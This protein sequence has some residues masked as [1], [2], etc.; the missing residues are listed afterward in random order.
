MAGAQQ[1]PAV[2]RKVVVGWGAAIVVALVVSWRI[3]VGLFPSP[4]ANRSAPVIAPA[5][6]L[7]WRP[8]AE[9]P[10]D[11]LQAS[12]LQA[13]DSYAWL[14]RSHTR[15]RVPVARAKVLYLERREAPDVHEHR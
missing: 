12:S 8:Y 9:P 10:P 15:A 4:G 1:Q 2:N 6:M 13:R 11:P 14:D 7:A 5:G 3:S